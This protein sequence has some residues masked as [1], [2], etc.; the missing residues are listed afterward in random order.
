MSSSERIHQCDHKRAYT[1]DMQYTNS[2]RVGV[3]KHYE[4]NSKY[5]SS[6]VA[7]GF[8]QASRAIFVR[9]DA[10]VRLFEDDR[11]Q[12]NGSCCRPAWRQAR[13]APWSVTYHGRI[14]A[15]AFGFVYVKVLDEGF[16]VGGKSMRGKT[17]VSMHGA[18][19]IVLHGR[20][21]CNYHCE[22]VGFARGKPSP[23]IIH[24]PQRALRFFVHGGDCATSG[25]DENLELV[26]GHVVT[27]CECNTRIFGPGG[28]CD[29]QVNISKPILTWQPEEG[30]HLI[31]Y[32]PDPRHVDILILAFGLRN[33]KPLGTL[34]VEYS[35]A[36]GECEASSLW[37]QPMP[38][39][40]R[41]PSFARTIWRRTVPTSNLL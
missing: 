37:N 24:H 1:D 7:N 17:T 16:V 4:T 33:A 25:H 12:C 22:G 2:S 36:M 19:H 31:T 15:P 26:A 8:P 39:G 41:L 30:E 5:R 34:I 13:C 32:D 14:V 35:I 11:P 27:Q 21:Q 29:T 18:R 9:Y 40:L 10:A 3:G 20:H 6:L 38:H 23:R 28:G